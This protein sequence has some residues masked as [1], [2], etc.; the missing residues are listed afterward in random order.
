M[1]HQRRAR[2]FCFPGQGATYSRHVLMQPGF[3]KMDLGSVEFLK[4]K[5]IILL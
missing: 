4:R 5:S 2:G 3:G 1:R